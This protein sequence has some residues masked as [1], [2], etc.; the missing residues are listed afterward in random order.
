LKIVW[1]KDWGMGACF[2]RLF[3]FSSSVRNV[4]VVDA[5]WLDYRYDRPR[6]RNLWLPYLWQ[7][8]AFDRRIYENDIYKFNA[9][10]I[11]RIIF[12]HNAVY[13]ACFYLFYE[14]PEMFNC[15]QP[16]ESLQTRIKEKTK[17]FRIQNTIG[18]HIRRGDHVASIANSPLS[19][20]IDKIKEELSID[21][22]TK[23]YVASDS[24]E[25]KLKLKELFGDAI[26]TSFKEV[27]RDTEEGITNA[28]IELYI[29][30]FTRKIYGSCYSSYSMLAAK[31]SS[32]PIEFL[33]TIDTKV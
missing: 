1:F 5:N 26:L 21:M 10:T 23:F 7:F 25:E 6:K 31:L 13:F 30:S 16:V 17:L 11:K 15:L 24:Q 28:L 2:H 4:E 22:Q 33:S 19:L 32:I 8:F 18:L 9:E 29:L 27:R 20:F 14:W 3:E 12:S